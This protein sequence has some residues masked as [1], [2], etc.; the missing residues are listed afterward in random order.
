MV[1]KKTDSL[2][3]KTLEV[4]DKIV[5]SGATPKIQIKNLF[6]TQNPLVIQIIDRDDAVTHEFVVNDTNAGDI[7]ARGDVKQ[8]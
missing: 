6:G 4:T 5:F 3:V 2:K 1:T 7:K 8:I